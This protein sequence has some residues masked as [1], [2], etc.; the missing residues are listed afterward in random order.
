MSIGLKPFGRG[1][2]KWIGRVPDGDNNCVDIQCEFAAWNGDGGA[3]TG[4]VRFAEFIPDAFQSDDASFGVSQ[5]PFGVLE[6]EKFDTLF[7]RMME[8]SGGIWT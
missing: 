6:Q 5:D 4:L 2:D 8:P 7:L 3:S 1:G